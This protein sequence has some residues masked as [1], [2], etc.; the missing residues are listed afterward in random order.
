MNRIKNLSF[1]VSHSSSVADRWPIE[2]LHLVRLIVLNKFCRYVFVLFGVLYCVHQNSYRKLST[3]RISSFL[4]V[5]IEPFCVIFLNQRHALMIKLW[6]ILVDLFSLLER[7][8]W[9]VGSPMAKIRGND[10]N[11]VFVVKILRKPF[12]ILFCKLLIYHS[13]DNGNNLDLIFLVK[14]LLDKG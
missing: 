4:N 6:D 3:N 11:G 1:Y 9:K 12:S 8:I 14:R 5:F 13:D 10:E 7:L 2:R